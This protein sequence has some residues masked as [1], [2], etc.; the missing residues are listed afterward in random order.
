MTSFAN[1]LEVYTLRVLTQAAVLVPL[2]VLTRK[3]FR[4][5][6]SPVVFIAGFCFAMVSFA[7]IASFQVMPIATAISIFFIEPLF[8]TLLARPLLGEAVGLRR[9]VAVGVGL[10]GAV[11]VIRPNFATFGWIALLP[12]FAALA[13]CRSK[14]ASSSESSKPGRSSSCVDCSSFTMFSGVMFLH[15]SSKAT[16]STPALQSAVFRPR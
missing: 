8:L 12:A 11:I 4:G 7:L 2:A 6:F 5:A 1:P 15:A 13:F 10:I 3:S 14:M 9:Y 16:K